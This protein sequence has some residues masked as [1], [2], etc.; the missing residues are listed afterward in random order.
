MLKSRVLAGWSLACFA[1]LLLAADIEEDDCCRIVTQLAAAEP[2]DAPA[3]TTQPAGPRGRRGQGRRRQQAQRRAERAAAASQAG[4]ASQPAARAGRGRG[5]PAGEAA[6]EGTGPSGVRLTGQTLYDTQPVTLPREGGGTWVAWVGYHPGGGDYLFVGVERDG[7]LDAV[8]QIGDE[9]GDLFRPVFVRSGDM[10]LLLY[11]RTIP[12]TG[13]RLEFSRLERDSWRKPQPVPDQSPHTLNLEAAAMPD[14]SIAIVYQVFRGGVYGIGLRTFD[15]RKWSKELPVCTP[16]AQPAPMDCWDPV[17]AWDSA[18]RQLLIAWVSYFGG[19]YDLCWAT[20][21][22]GKVGKP[23]RIVRDGYDLH[24]AVIADPKGGAWLAWDNITIRNHGGS[25]STFIKHPPKADPDPKPGPRL[26]AYVAAARWRD[27]RLTAPGGEVRIS[28]A[29]ENT[30]HGGSPRLVF[31]ASGRLYIAYRTLHEPIAQRTFYYWDITTRSLDGS[32]WTA[33]VRL[34]GSDGPT[35]E[36]SLQPDGDGAMRVFFQRDYRRT[37]I[38][39]DGNMLPKIA[40][41]KLAAFFDHH[42]DYGDPKL[43]HGDIY[44]TRVPGAGASGP[45][46]DGAV[47]PA[48]IRVRKLQAFEPYRKGEYTV[49]FGDLHRHSNVSRCSRGNEPDPDDHYRYS[50]DICRY[51]FLGVSDHAAHTSDYNWWRLQKL[52]DL[53]YTPGHFTTMFGVE[54]NG[55]EGHKNVMSPSRRLPLLATTG[56]APNA[57]KLWEALDAWGGPAITIPHSSSLPG[58]DCDWSK[59]NDKY[60]RL[61]EVFQSCRGSFEGEG[62]PRL[63][64]LATL[65]NQHVQNALAMKYRLGMICSSDHGYGASYACVYAKENTREAVF[66][67]LHDRRTYGA[68]AYGIIVDFNINGAMMGRDVKRDGGVRATGYVRGAAKL[69]K[70]QILKDNQVVQEWTPSGTELKVDWKDPEPGTGLHWYYLRV[71]QDDDEMAWSSPNW[72]E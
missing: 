13:P 59:H 63:F 12:G 37:K 40:N 65:K 56:V 58:Q 47:E 70:V 16:A 43:R 45:Q 4:A 8:Q 50:R 21:A 42:A 18:G 19:E 48:P 33:P 53:Y 11:T 72:V 36:P 5:E 60:Q 55:P 17:L 38:G 68:T 69:D 71:I 67:A 49:L 39:N 30:C 44:V 61:V 34:A 31:D 15:G 62:A 46:A 26:R 52:A 25:G 14:G 20:Y 23:T 66:D 29:D 7:K 28:G 2:S 1:S 10:T 57:L 41:G 64:P 22:D 35:E 3:V 9:P 24:P 6:P 54:W 51:D 32:K 27:G